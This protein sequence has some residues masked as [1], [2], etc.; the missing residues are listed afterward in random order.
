MYL[1]LQM[2][3]RKF[4]ILLLKTNFLPNLNTTAPLEKVIPAI[5]ETST[6]CHII[7]TITFHFTDGEGLSV[8]FR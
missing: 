5:Q 8:N 7:H 3:F 6:S 2:D 4:A 1:L